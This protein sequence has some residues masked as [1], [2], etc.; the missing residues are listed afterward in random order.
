MASTYKQRLASLQTNIHHNRAIH[1]FLDEDNLRKRIAEI[2]EQMADLQKQR[3]FFAARLAGAADER[4]A[5]DKGLKKME[6]LKK[7]FELPDDVMKTVISLQRKIDK[8]EAKARE[9]GIAD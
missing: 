1:R 8:A 3:D 5:L 4:E 6:K 7:I 9:D 2:D